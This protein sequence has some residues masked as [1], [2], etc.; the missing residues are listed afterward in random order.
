MGALRAHCDVED[1]LVQ[2][3]TLLPIVLL[4]GVFY[5][6]ILRPARTRQK[7]QQQ[8]ISA[9]SVGKQVMTTGGLFGTV[10]AISDDRIELE[11]ADGVRVQYL[12]AAVSRVVSDSDE[13]D[14]DTHVDMTDSHGEDSHDEDLAELAATDVT[15]KDATGGDTQTR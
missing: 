1:V 5:V 15:S 12:Q 9:L 2:P 10:T 7:T 3:Q 8:T 11:I 13:L 6:L 4:I 14:A